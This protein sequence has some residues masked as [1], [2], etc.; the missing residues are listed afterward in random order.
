MLK[1]NNLQ[2]AFLAKGSGIG[3]TFYKIGPTLRIDVCLA[4]T[5]MQVLQ[6]KREKKKLSDHY[7]VIADMK[8]KR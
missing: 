4:D 5:S 7:P 1:N 2:D 8:W 3:N 6:C